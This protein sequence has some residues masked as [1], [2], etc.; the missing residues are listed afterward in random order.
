MKTTNFRIQIRTLME[1]KKISAAKLA[2]LAD[3]NVGT[4][5]KYLQEE[6]EMTAANLEKMFDVLNELPTPNRKEQNGSH[7]NG[8]NRKDILN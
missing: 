6:S 3:L 5:Y 1:R 7:A 4:V 8:I 2:R